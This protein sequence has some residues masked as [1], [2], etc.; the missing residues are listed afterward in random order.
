MSFQ[1]IG[2]SNICSEQEYTGYTA[3]EN[4]VFMSLVKQEYTGKTATKNIAVLCL[5]HLKQLGIPVSV[6]SRS[7]QGT[8]QLST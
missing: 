8:Q 3:T 5:F 1:A 7:T 6:L 4:Q 2:Y